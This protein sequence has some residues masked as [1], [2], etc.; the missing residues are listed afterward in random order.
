V[1]VG[2][3][4]K[5]RRQSKAPK[6]ILIFVGIASLLVIG[7]VALFSTISQCQQ[8]VVL[9][10]LAAETRKIPAQPP[11]QVQINEQDYGSSI[12]EVEVVP[13]QCNSPS[14]GHFDQVYAK[15]MWGKKT[16][17]SSDFYGDAEWPPKEARQK[18]ASGPGSDLG[19]ATQTSLKIIK[20]TIVKFNVK[21]MI[22]VP[23]GDVNWI[24]D[25]LE[26]DT[27]P[28]YVGLDITSAVID[29]N[30]QRFSHHSNKRFYFWD[31]VACPLPKFK[32]GKSE[33]QPFDLV[34]VRDVIQH[35]PLKKGVTY[36]CNIF[37]SGA[38]VLIT[39]TYDKGIN[40]D[41]D[42]SGWYESNL[43]M[44]PFSFPA[45][46]SCTR[47]HPELE[48]DL[49]CVYDLTKPWVEAFITSKC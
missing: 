5:S 24:L 34:H 19:V 45:G 28:L 14:K 13:N 39:T 9:E 25:S 38:K 21:S 15:G 26:T 6:V 2:S 3:T 30:K 11:V 47:T 44:E 20:D 36:I 43:S 22:D 35:L 23:C 4:Q 42:E 46:D 40:K 37:K 1:T 8:Q 12:Q 49:T 29:I 16:R 17:Q 27:L 10:D 31:A 18:S 41:I 32:N 7:G 48:K 33:E